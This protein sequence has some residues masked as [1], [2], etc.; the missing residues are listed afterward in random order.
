MTGEEEFRGIE[1]E[2]GKCEKG[3]D[4]GARNKKRRNEIRRRGTL[5]SGEENRARTV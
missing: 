3:G 2:Q 4:V 5:R 1:R